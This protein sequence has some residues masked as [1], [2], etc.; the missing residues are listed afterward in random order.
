MSNTE[1]H[2]VDAALAVANGDAERWDRPNVAALVP[3]S[4][5]GMLVRPAGT[6]EQI[7]QAF[8]DYQSLCARLLDAS[9]FQRIGTK[10]FRKK[11][12]WRKLAV[13]FG[14]SCEIVSRTYDRDDAGR[15]LRAEVVMRAVAPNGRSME[16]IGICD[17][18]EKCCDPA[19]CK[20]PTT[21]ADSG[22][23]R[24]AHCDA[25]CPGTVH[26]SSA[27]HDIPATAMTRATNRACSDLFGM[28]EVSAEEIN[29]RDR[30]EREAEVGVL[31]RAR[32]TISARIKGFGAEKVK[33]WVAEQGLPE[34]VG[35]WSMADIERVDDYMD[36]VKIA[37][38]TADEAPFDAGPAL[39][40]A[41]T[42]WTGVPTEQREIDRAERLARAEAALAEAEATARRHHPP[43]STQRPPD[44]SESAASPLPL[45]PGPVTADS[46]VEAIIAAADAVLAAEGM[47]PLAAQ[48]IA[49][50]K[51]V[52]SSSG[53]SSEGKS[54]ELRL[55]IARHLLD[56]P[57]A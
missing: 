5:S 48:G 28:G 52:C 42:D 19:T 15:I 1:A 34:K 37:E 16:G 55:R 4:T 57:S 31:D 23:F 41:V 44:A 10:D 13:A 11:S 51:Q 46:P 39:A 33:A 22:K 25:G 12:A 21:W 8:H 18:R 36:A 47:Q 2:P 17:V 3:V 32:S 53:L 50:L 20:T 26:F 45:E 14:V 27:E 9:D 29:D 43:Q 24:H 40:D 30:A 38:R 35:Q 7:E 6:V 56:L 49:A 54:F